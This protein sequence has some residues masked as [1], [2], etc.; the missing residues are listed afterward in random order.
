MLARDN[1]TSHGRLFYSCL[2][3]PVL[4]VCSCQDHSGAPPTAE[5]DL[6]PVAQKSQQATTESD[7]EK[8]CHEFVQ[9]FYDWY[10]DRLNSEDSSPKNSPTSEEDVLNLK[11]AVLTPGLRQM[12]KDD[13]DAQ[14][15]DHD[16]IVGLDFD[17]YINAQDWDG[18]YTI[19]RVAVRDGTCR[20]VLFG[21]DGGKQVETVDP[22]LQNVSGKWVFVNFHYPDSKNPVNENL[23]AQLKML[24]D[25]RQKDKVKAAHK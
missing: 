3:I 10:F 24:R 19:R 5:K 2:L 14:D 18:K 7:P 21:D 23:I 16:Y 4:G 25:E 13:F 20:A 15:H 17:P 12:L 9:G 1:K 11:P 22:E 6:Q 8:S